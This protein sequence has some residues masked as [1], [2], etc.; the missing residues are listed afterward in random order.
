MKELF[1]I[2]NASEEG[3]NKGLMLR[4][5]DKPLVEYLVNNA[6]SLNIINNIEFLCYEY[7]TD[8][9]KI[10]ISSYITAKK[11][12]QDKEQ[13]NYRH[14]QDTRYGEL[15]L[16]FKLKAKDGTDTIVKRMLVPKVDRNGYITIRG[17]KYFLL[18]Q[19]VDKS[20]YT[21]QN[22]LTL[23]SCMAVTMTR[24]AVTNK[25]TKGTEYTAP[26]Y[27]V[28]MYKNERDVF[29][30]YFAKMGITKTLQ[31][32]SCNTIMRLVED[33]EDHDDEDTFLYFKVNSSLYIE[34]SKPMFEKF[35][36]VRS[37]VFMII[38]TCNNRT[39]LNTI[40]NITM[41]VEKLGSLSTTSQYNA[42]GK[43][44]NQ[45][46]NFESMVDITALDLLSL[47]TMNKQNV[48]TVI[49]WMIQNYAELRK[50]S[51]MDLDNKRLRLN[52]YI[53]SILSIELR[54]RVNQFIKDNK[55]SLADLKNI[56][57]FPGDLLVQNLHSSGLLR[58]DDAVN[59]CDFFT[60]LKFTIKGP[61]SVG[62]K[63]ERNID[64]S[65][66][67]IHDSHLGRFDI[68]VC[69][70]SDPG[71]SGIITPFC[72]DIKGLQFSDEN[73]PEEFLYE[74]ETSLGEHFQEH[75]PDNTVIIRY[76]DSDDYY[77]KQETFRDIAKQFKMYDS[78][79]VDEDTVLI[80]INIEDKTI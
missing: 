68:N 74:F 25:D 79:T 3:L 64:M 37:I 71:T 15:K 26:I 53:A 35:M 51:N 4:E 52:E 29:N 65:L 60:K 69:G 40:D 32:F 58:Y 42:Y 49:R 73:E 9:S 54:K 18:Y 45:L 1:H 14:L 56:F 38:D 5:D 10:D 43:G 20:T 17:K 2:Y 34:V 24:E 12:K 67:G 8:E 50:K 19:L 13:Y 39:K 75:D 59:D 11:R 62:G 31:Y 55:T 28:K 21:T 47:H 66:K 22:E 16:K 36:Y 48:L 7:E 6:K 78:Y 46:M 70:N 44:Q 33:V 30:L 23:K 41:W 57:K 72:K 27:Q 76:K 61:Q 80:Q 77:N 63:N